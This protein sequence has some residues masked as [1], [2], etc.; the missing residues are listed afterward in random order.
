MKKSLQRAQAGT[1]L[2][3][4][5]VP[6]EPVYPIAHLQADERERL[7]ETFVR[8]L[9]GVYV[10]LRLKRSMYG[11]DPVQR[12]RL[13]GQRAA[14]MDEPD[15]HAELSAIL[16]DLRDAHTRYASIAERQGLVAVLPFMV[17]L[18]GG[19]DAPRF[20]VSN[21]VED[22]PAFAGTEFAAG[23]EIE[24]WN[25]VPI[26]RAVDRYAERETG[27]RRDA[28]RQRALESLTFRALE[29]GPP[30][31]EYWV[32][33]GYRTPSGQAHEVQV[34]WRVVEVGAGD[35]TRSEQPDSAMAYAAN[36]AAEAVRRAKTLLFAPVVWDD[37]RRGVA[38]RLPRNRAVRA[39]EWLSG[40][41]AG[42]VSAK[43]VETDA[44]TFGYLR[45]W[46]FDLIDDS[47]FVD[48]VI[49]L[50]DRLPRRGLIVDV[51]ANP[52]GLIWA[53]E[54]LLQLFTPHR[55][56]P[57]RFSL[58]ATDLTREMAELPQNALQLE[59][60]RRSLADAVANGEPFSRAVPL[61]PPRL[62]QSTGQRY[63]GPVVCVADGNTYSAGDLFAAGFVDNRIGPLI[64]IGEATGAGGAN[65]WRRAD[66]ER[67][68]AG[69]RQPLP[70]L[71][72]SVSYTLSFRRAVR[73]G[74]A[75]G[76]LIE[77]LG[78]PGHLRYELTREDLTG[79]NRD[80]IEFCGR[81]L[82]SERSTDLQ[83]ERVG[84]A[85]LKVSAERLDRIDV[86]VDGRPVGSSAPDELPPA[87]ELGESWSAAEVR[88]F[89]GQ[90]LRQR[91][92]IHR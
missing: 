14:A 13:L 35:E 90:S 70:P 56:E 73:A 62:C 23:V 19:A 48:E 40:R 51:R 68:L 88:G 31:D 36:P 17:E 50:L 33:V 4:F 84:D 7:V 46:S 65:V 58:L 81:L 71:P 47:G 54:R 24:W 1:E 72:E 15:F 53:A 32:R 25:A 42:L 67:A 20:L 10:H 75:S 55:V 57:T 45:L 9:E 37:H 63:P 29:Y 89:V 6:S 66:V 76:T 60:W 38:K 78:V 21:V 41:F 79:G 83:V 22:E 18:F 61:T 80:L 86:Y 2:R 16:V 77:D 92:L 49:E 43:E 3:Q 74:S 52:G 82:A 5:A 85:G 91:R 27:G 8:L 59:P 12:L 30:P 28:R 11:K 87:I 26:A 69:A 34:E 64:T 39:G 44:G